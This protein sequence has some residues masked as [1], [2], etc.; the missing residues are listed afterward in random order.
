MPSL[1]NRP[2]NPDKTNSKGRNTMRNILAKRK[3]GVETSEA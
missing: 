1:V 2:K 3:N